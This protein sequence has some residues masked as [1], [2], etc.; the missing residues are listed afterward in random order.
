MRGT[1]FSRLEFERYVQLVPDELSENRNRQSDDIRCRFEDSELRG[2]SV[3]KAEMSSVERQRAVQNA[4]NP[5]IS[6][7]P[8][9]IDTAAILECS[10]PVFF[11]RKEMIVVVWIP[12]EKSDG[13]K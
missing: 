2:I 9:K 1:D 11:R 5:Q 10:S 8:K 3:L 13:V 4:E 6:K 12:S 7:R